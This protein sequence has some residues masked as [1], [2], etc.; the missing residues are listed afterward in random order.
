[1]TLRY[2][3]PK[4]SAPSWKV[5]VA[6]GVRTLRCMPRFRASVCHLRE[7]AVLL[8]ERVLLERPRAR[9]TRP[10]LVKVVITG[11]RECRDGLGVVVVVV[12]GWPMAG[13]L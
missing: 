7:R 6:E 10:W 1:M 5:L 2:T 8:R 13:S 9:C 11:L 12:A 3:A 4:R